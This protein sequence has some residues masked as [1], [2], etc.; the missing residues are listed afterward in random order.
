MEK[1]MKVWLVVCVLFGCANVYL[2]QNNQPSPESL[3][4]LYE[5]NL[6]VKRGVIENI[7]RGQSAS[8]RPGN[9]DLK[10][11]EKAITAVEQDIIDLGGLYRD[12]LNNLPKKQGAYML[13]LLVESIV[14]SLGLFALGVLI[15]WAIESFRSKKADLV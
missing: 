11:R 5:L 9:N 12:D 3:A 15:G 1:C 8:V 4:A 14:K 7:K 2:K 6:Q 13:T 10:G